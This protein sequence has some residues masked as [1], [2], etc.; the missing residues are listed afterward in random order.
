MI[1]PPSFLPHLAFD[2]LT[3]PLYDSNQ[4][5]I[6]SFQAISGN[7]NFQHS[8]YQASENQGPLP[9][10]EYTF[11]FNQIDE[12]E[13]GEFWY[14]DQGPGAWGHTRL[15]IN[16]VQFEDTSI[17]RSQFYIHGGVTAGSLGC[18]D[19]L[20]ANQEFFDA[21]EAFAQSNPH[22]LTNP[23]A[24]YVDDTAIDAHLAT[25]Q[26]YPLLVDQCFPSGAPTRL[27]RHRSREISVLH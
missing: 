12:G 24:F 20:G 27:R 16:I 15:P 9:E 4:A 7:P 13:A 14:T 21:F 1:A 17:D 22:F 18:V 26:V 11:Y 23:L 8:S 10:G 3:F 25:H 2:G 5:H 19:L 6:F